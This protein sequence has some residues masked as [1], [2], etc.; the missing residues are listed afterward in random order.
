MRVKPIDTLLALK[1]LSYA[2]GSDGER[3]RRRCASDRP[4]QSENRSMRSRTGK[5]CDPRRRQCPHRDAIRTP[6]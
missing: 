2:A 1:V 4:V 5:H 6:A 3:P